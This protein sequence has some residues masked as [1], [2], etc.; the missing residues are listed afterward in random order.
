MLRVDWSRDVSPERTCM[1]ETRFTWRLFKQLKSML[2]MLEFAENRWEP[3]TTPRRM[4]ISTIE[5]QAWGSFEMLDL[6][7]R[8]IYKWIKMRFFFCQVRLTQCTYG[9]APLTSPCDPLGPQRRGWSFAPLQFFLDP[10]LWSKKVRFAAQ[11]PK[12]FG[13]TPKIWRENHSSR[14]L[15][16]TKLQGKSHLVPKLIW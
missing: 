14:V 1:V 13:E 4:R 15:G 11:S 5:L 6:C 16:S 7:T 8:T 3:S 9:S 2:V 12:K 10:F